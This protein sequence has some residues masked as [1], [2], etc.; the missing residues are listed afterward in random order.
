MDKKVLYDFL[1][2]YTKFWQEVLKEEKVKLK[3]ISSGNI[4]LV[5][6]SINDQQAIIMQINNM[7]NKRLELQSHLG[8]DNKTF[9][10]VIDDAQQPYK[11]QLIDNMEIWSLTIEEIK[12]YNEKC[13]KIAQSHLDFMGNSDKQQ[14]TTYGVKINTDKSILGKKI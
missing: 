14:N 12:A 4:E 7:E 5:E 2:E 1:N 11:Q 8:L 3:N 10:E 9:K 6:K 13:K